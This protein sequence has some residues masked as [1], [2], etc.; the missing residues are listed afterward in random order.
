M[1]PA[2]IAAPK[3]TA[4]SRFS[5]IFDKVALLYEGRQIFFGH[6]DA[7]KQYFTDMGYHCPDRQTTADFLT[8]LTN[9][10]ERIVQPGFENRVPRTPDEFAATWAKSTAGARLLGDIAA[11]EKEFPLQGQQVEELTASRRAKQASLV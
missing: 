2:A 4:Y 10:A 3:Q 9:P 8:S 6:K 11:F 7:A 1:T 5:Q